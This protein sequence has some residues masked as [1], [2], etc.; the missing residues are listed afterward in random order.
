MKRAQA[1]KTY[2]AVESAIEASKALR[3]TWE[4]LLRGQNT[5]QW[6]SETSDAPKNSPIRHPRHRSNPK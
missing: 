3:G 5:G 2:D 6:E 1:K 4:Q